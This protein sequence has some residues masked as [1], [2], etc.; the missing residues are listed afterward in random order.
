MQATHHRTVQI[1]TRYRV[2]ESA[3]VLQ[4]VLPAAEQRAEFLAFYILICAFWGTLLYM[5]M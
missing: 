5:A 2:E 4:R 1:A 3:R